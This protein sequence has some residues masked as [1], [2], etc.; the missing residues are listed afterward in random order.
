MLLARLSK[1]LARSRDNP[2]ADGAKKPAPVS[3]T[4]GADDPGTTAQPTTPGSPVRS[5]ARRDTT[6][7]EPDAA[8]VAAQVALQGKE[9]TNPPKLRSKATKA[10]E[11]TLDN[12][13]DIMADAP[14][15]LPGG[16]L[17][18]RPMHPQRTHNSATQSAYHALASTHACATNVPPP[19]QRMSDRNGTCPAPH[20]GG[21]NSRTPRAVDPA[22][23]G[24]QPSL[25][26]TPP[27][28]GTKRPHQFPP[29]R[30][31]YRVH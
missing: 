10:L 7:D 28:G 2:S 17:R 8:D 22:P 24:R 5:R 3:H 29:A 31:W 18:V 30:E 23:P 16:E 14:T 4:D 11:T 15:A 1:P 27:L 20:S 19:A 26:F 21:A 25:M 9:D 12:W 6:A 13:E